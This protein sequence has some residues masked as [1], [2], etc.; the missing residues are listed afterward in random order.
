MLFLST[1]LLYEETVAQCVQCEHIGH[2]SDFFGTRSTAWSIR[3]LSTVTASL[4]AFRGSAVLRLLQGV[5]NKPG[6][7]TTPGF[8]CITDSSPSSLPVPP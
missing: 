4:C 6:L 7:F 3:S 2:T 1:V 5:V 8:A